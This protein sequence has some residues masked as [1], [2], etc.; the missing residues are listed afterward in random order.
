MWI[1]QMDVWANYFY[2]I[3]VIYIIEKFF[4]I[5]INFQ[6]LWSK[7]GVHY[8]VLTKSPLCSTPWPILS[9]S[10]CNMPINSCLLIVWPFKNQ[11]VILEMYSMSH[12]MDPKAKVVIKISYFFLDS[13][14][15]WTIIKME[16]LVCQDSKLFKKYLICKENNTIYW[17]EIK[18]WADEAIN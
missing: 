7:C 5:G 15:F 3:A 1:L 8:C 9:V 11:K 13:K 6:T 10:W 4:W 16:I 18:Q 12:V 2:K 17:L 14:C